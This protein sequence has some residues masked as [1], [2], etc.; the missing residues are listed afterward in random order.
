MVALVMASIMVTMAQS[1]DIDTLFNESS[2]TL[3][4]VPLIIKVLLGI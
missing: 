3:T 1:Q 4:A 2:N